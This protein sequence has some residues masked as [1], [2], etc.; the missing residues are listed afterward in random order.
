MKKMI[1]LICVALLAV[2]VFFVSRYAERPAAD[3]E[4]NEAIQET[5]D[6]RA[7]TEGKVALPESEDD[8]ADTEGEVALREPEDSQAEVEVTDMIEADDEMTFSVG[9]LSDEIKERIT[10]VSYPEGCSVPYED[11]RYLRLKYVDYDGNDRAGEMICNKDIAEDLIEIFTALYEER[12]PINSIRLIDDY[13]GDD[14]ASMADDNTS[15]F[16]YRMVE[17]SGNLSRHAYGM[18]VDL[19]PFCNPYITYPGGTERISPPGSE[20]Y[21]DRDSGLPHMIDRNDPAYKLFT[22]HGFSWG[23]D[24]KTMKDYQHFYK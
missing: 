13:G 6:N 15:C 7:D 14:T 5:E 9:H 21:A 4:S 2:G 10:G 23:G 16:N 24:W 18:A 8:Q 22:A 11:L 20:P 3:A 12:Y 17:G 1:A 19:N